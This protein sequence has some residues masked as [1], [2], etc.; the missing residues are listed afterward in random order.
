MHSRGVRIFAKVQG[1]RN[2]PLVLLIHGFGGGSF[3]FELL[4]EELADKPL[5]VAA[6]DLRGY[7]KSDKTPRGYDLTTAASDMAG[8]IRGLGYTDAL[9]V[10]HGY[11][12][13]VGW[14][15][16]SHEPERVRGVVTLSSAHPLVQLSFIRRNPVMNWH[17]TRRIVSA[18]LPRLPESRLV[19]HDAALAERIF[20]QSCAPGFRDTQAYKDHARR[21]RDAIQV[22]KVAHLASEYQRW[23]F[24]MHWRVEGLLF[25]RTF[26]KQIAAPV[27][28]IE[29]S[30][31]PGY[32]SKVT[33]RS[34]ARSSSPH[35]RAV[36]L[37]GVGHYPHVEDAPAVARI[38][39]EWMSSAPALN[40]KGFE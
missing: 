16:A 31:D 36:L 18:Q 30:M 26:P 25:E 7:G 8:V 14:T 13:L 28:A 2:A 33:Q 21:R 15:L 5:R 34:I 29:G 22:D 27:L 9:V 6:V 10:G 37:Y 32:V 19:K 24:R 20:R 17:R 39:L 4:M 1:P 12:G 11:G 35:S 3:D 38:L 23:L 40:Q